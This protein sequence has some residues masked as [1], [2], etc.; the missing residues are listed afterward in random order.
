MISPT[1]SVLSSTS[2]E[3]AQSAGFPGGFID[4]T[5][6]DITALSERVGELGMSAKIYFCEEGGG[7]FTTPQG[8]IK[9]DRGDLIYFAPGQDHQFNLGHFQAC[10]LLLLHFA[11][12]TFVR[13]LFGD[14]DVRALFDLL[15]RNA[16]CGEHRIPQNAETQM[17][18][19]RAFRKL[20]EQVGRSYRG[21]NA[22]IKM[23]VFDLAIGLIMEP[24]I[25]DRLDAEIPYAS[26]L[27]RL[28]KVLDHIQE[29]FRDRI[30]VKDMAELSRLSRSHFHTAFRK[31]TGCS[32]I[33]YVNRFRL[34]RAK[35]DLLRSDKP[36]SQIAKEYGFGNASRFSTVH[37]QMWGTTPNQASS[38]LSRHHQTESLLVHRRTVA[39][40][41]ASSV[42]RRGLKRS[43]CSSIRSQSHTSIKN[44]TQPEKRN[45]L[46][47][48]RLVNPL[49]G[50][51]PHPQ[52]CAHSHERCF[53][54]FRIKL[55]SLCHHLGQRQLFTANNKSL[56]AR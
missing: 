24:K 13:D 46:T 53:S 42:V 12:H 8:D 19:E 4:C 51:N 30:A 16:I 22:V 56:R 10:R 17:C 32:L 14:H 3:Q 31:A 18:T 43:W 33:E 50:I 20:A 2:P 35:T 27:G 44:K 47:V 7:S 26:S 25:H 34:M 6:H 48:I 23:T 37:K 11:E 15:D 5:I 45:G 36:L 28:S 52:R 29:N 54:K 1:N 9:V 41:V 49:I 21:R 39:Q 38:G 40:S 55:A